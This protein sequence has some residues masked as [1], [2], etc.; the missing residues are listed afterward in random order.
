MGRDRSPH[1]AVY[2][3]LCNITESAVCDVDIDE[4]LSDPCT[5]NSTCWDSNN[6][7]T[8]VDSYRCRCLP[9]W[10]NGWC[11]ERTPVFYEPICNVRTHPPIPHVQSYW[12][13]SILWDAK[14]IFVG[15]QVTGGVCDVDIDEC[16]SSPCQNAANCTESKSEPSCEHYIDEGETENAVFRYHC[17][18]QHF[19]LFYLQS[20]AS[21]KGD[22]HMWAVGLQAAA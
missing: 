2:E 21:R 18:S 5:H 22:L 6:N 12:R 10:A 4:C 1:F 17:L 16:A 15:R 9:G 13:L 3:P 14:G 20:K 19:P 8:E 11:D 7:D